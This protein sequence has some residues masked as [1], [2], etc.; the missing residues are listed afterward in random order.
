MP[1]VTEMLPGN[2]KIT[3]DPKADIFEVPVEAIVIPVNTKG[4][5][6]AG[7]ALQAK[8]LYPDMY[9]D[10]RDKCHRGFTKPGSVLA[11]AVK[12]N[13][14]KHTFSYILSLATK[15]HW[16]DKSE[17][18]YIKDGLASLK[19]CTI[20]LGLRSI[21]IPPLG[22]GCGKLSKEIVYQLIRDVYLQEP[23]KYLRECYLV[24]F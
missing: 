17:Y 8:T 20:S 18:T 10:Y 13:E 4:V 11:Y 15:D 6:G 23:F 3:I 9:L 5:M 12:D 2:L 24:Q 22:C 16:R 14:K 19:T 21:A 1:F 7:L